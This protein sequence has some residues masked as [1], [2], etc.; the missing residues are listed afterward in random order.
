MNT[1]KILIVVNVFCLLTVAGCGGQ[2]YKVAPLPASTPPELSTNSAGG[3]NLGATALDGDQSV[4]QFEANLPLAGV[5]AVDVRL[6][7]R[8]SEP[9]NANNLRFEL[10]DGTG[11]KF[12]KIPPKK[13]LSRV[14][15]FDGY[16]FYRVDARQRTLE[17]YE[18]IALK[19]DGVIGPQ[20]DRRGFLFF[21]SKTESSSFIGMTLSVTGAGIPN[22]LQLK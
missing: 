21:E 12:K 16:S 10:S 9:I 1:G 13:A 19:L 2:L 5:I 3:L 4:E 6:Q 15:K 11:A 22:S 8:S 17:N 7:N 14:M 20:E 18:A